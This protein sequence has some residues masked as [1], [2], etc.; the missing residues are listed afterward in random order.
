MDISS[1]CTPK[2]LNLSPTDILGKVINCF[3]IIIV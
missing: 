2:D 1:K 3:I